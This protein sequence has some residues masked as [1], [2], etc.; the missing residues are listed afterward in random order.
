MKRTNSNVFKF[1]KLFLVLLIA[2]STIEVN[3]IQAQT[4]DVLITHQFKY[5][6]NEEQNQRI[7]L[8]W[9]SEIQT[10]DLSMLDKNQVITV[11]FSDGMTTNHQ[12]IGFTMS[13]MDTES[14][15]VEGKDYE[16]NEPSDDSQ[17][18][19]HKFQI[20]FINE[21]W[22]TTH[23]KLSYQTTITDSISQTYQ[24][25]IAYAGQTSAATY[26]F[27]SKY[28][29]INWHNDDIQ[30]KLTTAS[31]DPADLSL[32]CE[33]LEDQSDQDIEVARVDIQA[34][35]TEYYLITI[36]KDGEQ[37]A[38]DEDMKVVLTPIHENQNYVVYVKQEHVKEALTNQSPV[39]YLQKKTD[40]ALSEHRYPSSYQV[41]LE[42]S[43]N[44][45][46]PYHFGD[47]NEQYDLFYVLSNYNAFSFDYYYGTHVVGPIIAGGEVTKVSTGSNQPDYNTALAIGGTTSENSTDIYEHTVPTYIGGNANIV[48]TVITSSYMPLFL[49]QQHNSKK[50]YTLQNK[51]MTDA[52]VN[53]TMYYNYYLQSDNYIDFSKAK[54]QFSKQAQDLKTFQGIDAVGHHM[55][56]V[57]VTKS[58][59]DASQANE[60]Y[61]YEKSS[62]GR[63]MRLKLGYNY[64][65]EEGI[66]GH[67]DYI[68]YDYI[69]FDEATTQTT[70]L[71]VPDKGTITA[72]DFYKAIQDDLGETLAITADEANGIK[73]AYLFNSS[74]VEKALNIVNV[75]PNA[76]KVQIG[77]NGVSNTSRKLVGHLVAPNATV[78]VRSGDY[79]GTIIANK[80]SSAA[81][82]HMWPFQLDAGITVNKT[83]NHQLPEKDEQFT[84]QLKNIAKPA[85]AEDIPEQTTTNQL[86]GSIHYALSDFTVEGD[87]IYEISEVPGT[88][89]YLPNTEKFYVYVKVSK[90]QSSIGG[91]ELVPEVVGYYTSIKKEQN[92][93]SI[94][95]TSKLHETPTFN[96]T[97]AMSVRKQW[98]DSEGNLMS[99]EQ[100]PEVSFDLIQKAVEDQG[101]TVDYHIYVK[102]FGSNVYQKICSKRSKPISKN[103]SFKMTIT[104][105]GPHL[106]ASK[107][108]SSNS[109]IKSKTSYTA[110]EFEFDSVNQNQDV[111][112]YYDLYSSS[113][114]LT[115]T[116]A[117]F[118][119]VAS[120]DHDLIATPDT[121]E[122]VYESEQLNQDNQWMID[123][124]ELPA[125]GEVNGKRYLYTYYVKETPL[126][127]YQV[128]YTNNNGITSGVIT[129]TNTLLPVDIVIQK[130][131][132]TGNT[133][134][135]NAEFELLDEHNKV[136]TFS[137]IND[138]YRID[139]N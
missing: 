74:E 125:S 48:N 92:V 66:Y 68:V 97:R 19:Y 26:A 115:A 8:S 136:C 127:G 98:K 72:P 9:E 61:C 101:Y 16:I 35:H 12:L 70:F 17:S 10:T 99:G 33:K 25:D 27:K 105:S 109:S 122:Q 52:G 103:K 1:F 133:V 58:S 85:D 95:E 89:G 3:H 41:A 83:V 37:I 50:Q 29:G 2:L 73:A 96:N 100:T 111:S 15:L 54:E 81:E 45:S 94:D 49:N 76:E 112:I 128:S 43:I 5:E 44:H 119:I 91:G 47:F 79:N 71:N 110:A 87:Y 121:F 106:L 93:I 6:Q 64:V 139:T 51:Q 21:Q 123:F 88:P 80:I 24:S 30:L 22:N 124:N 23:I 118:T 117:D 90:S 62:A 28:E 7:A 42:D 38:F 116:A 134:L 113:N 55:S 18:N 130:I 13:D 84:F 14:V 129:I 69:G 57:N 60:Y 82:G 77:F 114:H 126:S 11:S 36:Y 20:R 32:S 31:Y 4:D 107:V 131:S 135:Q 86:S 75:L 102:T 67:L 108:V 56:I 104:S 59:F 132:Y 137:K 120:N 46:S 53:N 78:D 40:I 34:E 39:S 63:G 138:V 65:F